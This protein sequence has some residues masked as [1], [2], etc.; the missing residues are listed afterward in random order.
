MSDKYCSAGKCECGKYWDEKKCS[1]F[2]NIKKQYARCMADGGDYISKFEVCP[3]PSRQVQVEVAPE[4]V[5]PVSYI[6]GVRRGRSDM[7]Q[8][9]GV[10]VNEGLNMFPKHTDNE[11]ECPRCA[12]QNC[13]SI[14]EETK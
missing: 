13:I 14:I 1:E 3:W 4:L 5:N 2:F 11:A 6:A 12:I 10:R 8:E 7:K 9:I